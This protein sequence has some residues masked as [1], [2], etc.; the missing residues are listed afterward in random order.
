MVKFRFG[1][2]D[3]DKWMYLQLQFAPE[4][5]KFV[6]NLKKTSKNKKCLDD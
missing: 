3:I 2:K 6:Q 5:I 1:R 4:W